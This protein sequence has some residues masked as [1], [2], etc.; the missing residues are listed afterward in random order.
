MVYCQCVLTDVKT[1]STDLFGWKTVNKFIKIL[2][3]IDVLVLSEKSWHSV[4]PVLD[5]T[6]RCRVKKAVVGLTELIAALV[7]IHGVLAFL[8]DMDSLFD[9][10]GETLRLPVDHHCLGPVDHMVHV[11]NRRTEYQLLVMKATDRGRNV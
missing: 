10:P 8:A 11:K 3:T 1:R 2:S 6:G 7:P 5:T 4:L 9:P